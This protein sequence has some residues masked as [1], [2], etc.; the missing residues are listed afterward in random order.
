VKVPLLDLAAQ[1]ETIGPELRAAVL[2]VVD[3]TQYIG[4]PRVERFER[5]MEEYLGVP[6]AVGVSSG[7]DALI[8]A[9]MTLGLEPGDVVLTTPYTFFATAGSVTRLGGRPAFCDID[10]SSYNMCP[11]SLE[12]RLKQELDAGSRVRAII[13]VHLYGQCAEMD[14]ILAV[15]NEHDI[16]VIE[17]AAQVIGGTYPS[18]SGKR[19]AGTMGLCGTFSFFPSKNLGAIGDAGMVISGDAAFGERLKLMRNHGA[20][21]KYYHS[22]VGGNFRLDP[23]QAAALHVKLPHLAEW[24]EARRHNAAYYDERFAG[25]KIQTPALTWE[26]EQHIYHQYVISVPEK[27][28]E[29]CRVLGENEIGHAIYYPV[30]LHLQECFADL[31]YARG[32]L[33]VSEHAAEHTVAIPIYP[34]LTREQQD[35]VVDCVT[36]FYG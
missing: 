30:P 17:D 16:P 36:G 27:R 2:E 34:E 12:Q 6:H 13:P 4:G 8:V 7:T 35:T 10:P 33:P 24:S 25:T 5:A 23:I 9:L 32:S 15:A 26:R 29:L 21:P 18:S 3:S 1:L 31:G 20:K 19:V 11:Q 28:D 14:R 22:M